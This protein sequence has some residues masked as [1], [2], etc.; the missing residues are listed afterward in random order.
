MAEAQCS[1]F[2][3]G[4]QAYLFLFCSCDNCQLAKR[5][6]RLEDWD[7]YICVKV[8]NF[9][10]LPETIHFFHIYGIYILVS[11]FSSI[12]GACRIL[13]LKLILMLLNLF[14]CKLLCISLCLSIS[15]SK[16]CH[17]IIN[18]FFDCLHP[19]WCFS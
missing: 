11:I 3:S 4:F 14:C 10:E 7:P 2:F 1:Y 13:N 17:I 16:S 8:L 18:I 5:R 6:Q 12:N 15:V 19:A 9:L